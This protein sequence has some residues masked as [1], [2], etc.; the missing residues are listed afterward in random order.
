MRNHGRGRLQEKRSVKRLGRGAPAKAKTKSSPLPNLLT[1]LSCASRPLTG[2]SFFSFQYWVER[3]RFFQSLWR[4]PERT[5]LSFILPASTGELRLRTMRTHIQLYSEFSCPRVNLQWRAV[6]KER[7]F[8]P[9]HSLKPRL[10][11]LLTQLHS[12]FPSH[13][14]FDWAT[15]V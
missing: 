5:F 10:L 12:W 3:R 7:M 9:A 13:C 2:S 14:P 15:K 11:S 1:V 6:M 4:A 8:S